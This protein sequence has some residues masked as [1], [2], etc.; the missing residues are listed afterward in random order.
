M[1]VA[2][3]QLNPVVG[4]IAGNIRQL[5]AALKQ[6]CSQRVD[7][8]VLPELF[9]TGYP[10]K[11]LLEL[12]WFV[13]KA[14]LALKDVARLSH[15]YRC[16]ILVGGLIRN[17]RPTG[18]GI[19][20]CALGFHQGEQVFC[21]P[22]LLLPFYDVFDETRY[23]DPGS[24]V[25]LWNFGDERLG[26]SICEDAWNLPQL[27]PKYRYQ[28]DPIAEQARLGATLLLNI[29]A[30]PFWLGKPA[31][32]LEM[33]KHHCIRHRLPFI[34]VN[35][36][37]AN[38]ELIFDGNSLVMDADGN[39]RAHLNPFQEQIF[40]FDTRSLPAAPTIRPGTETEEE[41]ESVY[42][43]LVLGIRDYFRKCG[44]QKAVIG[45]S[46]GIDS[47]VT[48]CL[49]VAALTPENVLG[50]TMPSEFSSEGSVND[51]RRLATNLGIELLTIPITPLFRQFLTSLKPVFGDR[52]WDETEENIQARLR[53]NILMAL[54]NKFNAL[55]LATGNKSELAVGYCTLYG[56]LSGSLAAIGDLPKTMV[57]KLACHINRFREIIP[58]AIITKTPSAELRPNQ[59]DEDNLP[60]YPLLDQILELHIEAGHSADEIIARGLP[61]ETV[62]WVVRQVARME[63]KR[64]QAPLVL[65]VTSRAFGT[66]RRFPIAARYQD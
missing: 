58:Q 45:L 63:Y 11:D 9:I 39:I 41:M 62:R 47:A 16:A 53:G 55:V 49:A 40:V 2:I 5:E 60:P 27:Q 43:A 3:A 61:P 17:Q 59:K 14:E 6:V 37:G 33:F 19:Y 64:R 15:E 25:T 31:L 28:L 24:E 12:P 10:P 29:S 23:F 35:Q 56:D 44:F 7:L 30:S 42:Q 32:R 46:G 4:D 8:L 13:Q 51:S 50:V 36:V 65:R 1:R 34:F 66:G 57:Y 48:A 21:Q 20:N 18:R 22:K 26:V 52:P 54:A 38:D